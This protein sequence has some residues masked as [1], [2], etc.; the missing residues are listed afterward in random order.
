MTAFIH[1]V[2]AVLVLLVLMAVG[3]WMGHKGWI[4]P[5][6]KSFLS[7]FIINIA[8]PCNCVAGILNNLQRDM[9]AQAATLLLVGLLLMIASLAV[10]VA[11]ACALRLPRRRWGLFV[12]MGA[13]SNSLFVGVPLGTELFGQACLP[14]I[15]IYYMCNTCFV[16][17]VGVGLI[18]WSGDQPSARGGVGGF[19]RSLITKPPVLAIMVS[20]LLLVANV[21][22]PQVVMSVANYISG[23][24][25][26]LALMYSGYVV[27]EL[28]LKNLRFQRGLPTML[29]MRLALAPVLCFWLSHAFGVTGLPQAVFVM[30]SALPVVSQ[31]PVLAGNFGADDQYAAQGAIL[32]TLGCLLT[33]P[34]L[35]LFLG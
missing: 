5:K 22:P 13:M 6:E 19:A 27:Y 20:V 32:S 25:A 17:T 33:I 14:Y 12:V 30:E 16:Q 1:G 31:V 2:S 29:V 18:Q 34:I 9:L 21:R 23:C 8:V 10:S 7:R 3:F 4:G 24:V 35:M 11:L 28:G 26:P 15:M